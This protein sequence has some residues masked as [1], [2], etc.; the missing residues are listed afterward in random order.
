AQVEEGDAGIVRHAE[1]EMCE[2]ALLARRS[3]R[4][5]G[6]H[7]A[8][9][10]AE[11]ILVERAGLLRIAA[12]PGEVMKLLDLRSRGHP[13]L[14]RWR[15]WVAALLNSIPGKRAISAREARPRDGPRSRC[16]GGRGDGTPA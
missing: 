12:S 4:I 1:E 13:V 10:E 5:S 8:E 2:P 9:R 6:D 7:M 14:I 11:Q 15:R 3:D 16:F